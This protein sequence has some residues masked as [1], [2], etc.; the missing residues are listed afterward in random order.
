MRRNP[1][2]ENVVTR[3][4]LGVVVIFAMMLG[5]GVVGRAFESIG[6]PYGSWIGVTV[7]TIAVFLVFTVLY[8]RYLTQGESPAL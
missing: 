6:V 2:E 8:N 5:G 7:G 1:V 3:F 4:V